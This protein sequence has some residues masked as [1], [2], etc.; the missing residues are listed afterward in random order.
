MSDMC[1]MAPNEKQEVQ[2]QGW[3]GCIVYEEP[4]FS[5][6]KAVIT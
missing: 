3:H 5:I 1:L 2:W 4:D 6:D